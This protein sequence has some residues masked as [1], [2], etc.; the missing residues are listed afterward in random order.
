MGKFFPL[1]DWHNADTTLL[2]EHVSKEMLQQITTALFPQKQQKAQVVLAFFN[3]TAAAAAVLLVI[4]GAIIL[5][6]LNSHPKKNTVNEVTI[7]HPVLHADT[8]WMKKE[9]NTKKTLTITLA[10]G[11]QVRLQRGAVVRYSSVYGRTKRDIWLE[12][13]AFFKVAKQHNKPFTVVTQS[14][15]TTALGTSFTVAASGKNVEVKLYTG[16]VV[17][18]PVDHLPGFTKE[19]YISPGEM[20]TYDAPKSLV[21]VGK[22]SDNKTRAVP[23][24]QKEDQQDLVFDNADLA[25]VMATLSLRYHCNINFNQHEIA[26]MNFTGTISRTDSPGVILRLIANM[27]NLIIEENGKNYTVSKPMP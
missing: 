8:L 6:L 2:P 16:K 25:D 3:K 26:G 15:L 21:T 23:Q 11:S 20:V 13:K 4:T 14:L 19:V 27:N 1:A 22:Y 5:F 9:N 7:N 17:V 24:Q 10:D 18:K 12:G